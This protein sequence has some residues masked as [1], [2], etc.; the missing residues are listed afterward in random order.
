MCD[1]DSEYYEDGIA[2]GKSLY[3]NY[4][5]IPELT[6]PLASAMCEQL[7]ISIEDT[8]LDFGCAKGYLVKALG[9]LG[10]QA[11]G[12]DI[13]SYALSC[14]PSE[15]KHR[16]RSSIDPDDFYDWVIAKDVLE[17]ID[18]KF[19]PSLML[20]FRSLCSNLFIIIPLGL[21]NRYVIPDYD[22]DVTHRVRQ[23]LSWWT[24]LAEDAGFEVVSALYHQPFM[25]ANWSSYEKGNGFII[26]RN[27]TPRMD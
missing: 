22:K 10:R 16:C 27:L 23:P 20:R 4:C 9:L 8:V 17:H 2:S 21:D 6:I 12:C 13:S 5:W 15:I 11:W 1:Y 25:K 19:L 3:T 14:V 18:E 7:G 24:K 26:L